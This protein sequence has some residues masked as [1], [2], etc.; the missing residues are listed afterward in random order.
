M[1][2]GAGGAAVMLPLLPSLIGDAAAQTF[3]APKRFI[4]LFTSNGM[5]GRNWYPK[6][7]PSW[8]VLAPNVRESALTGNGGISTVLGPEFDSLKSKLL[9]VR[10]LDTMFKGNDAGAHNFTGTLAATSTQF[11]GDGTRYGVTVDQVMAQSN[12]VYPWVPGMRSVHMVVSST[13]QAYHSISTSNVGGNLSEV[14]VEVDVRA[15]YGRLFNGFTGGGSTPPP[16]PMVSKGAVKK[17][18]IDR[19][20]AEYDTL[21]KSPRLSA[22]DKQRLDAHLTHLKDLEARIQITAPPSPPAT[23]VKPAAPA[24]IATSD[25]YALSSYAQL[26]SLNIDTLV[27]AIRCDRTRVAT[28]MLCPQSDLRRFRDAGGSDGDHH[29]VSHGADLNLGNSAGFAQA[30]HDLGVINNWY[31][32]RV[33]E[34]LTKLDVVEDPMTGRT[35]LDN[36]IVF[37]GNE[38]GCSAWNPHKS[39]GMPVLLAGGG[40]GYFHPGRYLDYRKY[41]V[42]NGQEQYAAVNDGSYVC[43]PNGGAFEAL[44]RPYNALMVTLLQAMGLSPSDYESSPGAGFGDYSQNVNNQYSLSEGKSV[45]PFI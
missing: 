9:L 14:P 19:V 34:L 43:D 40:G 25:D 7:S 42:V 27:A 33:A 36:S 3:V 1:L 35:Y 12:T 20:R 6:V 39:I 41:T 16:V 26:T 28:L 24:G 5:L 44:G 2:L 30:E 22:A 21:R 15:T 10:G 18:V 17:S 45:L 31:A 29:G 13:A 11:M 32:K 4:C 37:W 38:N 8:K 23:C